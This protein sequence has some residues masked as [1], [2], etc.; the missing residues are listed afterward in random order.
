MFIAELIASIAPGKVVICLHWPQMISRA[1][2]DLSHLCKFNCV[3][4]Q[5]IDS[6]NKL[7]PLEQRLGFSVFKAGMNLIC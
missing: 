6:L 4:E 2:N 3:V 5:M 7:H 1:L